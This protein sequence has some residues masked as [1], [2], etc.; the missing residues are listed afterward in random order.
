MT[1]LGQLLP[2]VVD[3]GGHAARGM[4]E[5]RA[6]HVAAYAEP[7]H[8]GCGRAPQALIPRH[9]TAVQNF[10]AGLLAR[11]ASERQVEQLTQ[12]YTR[13]L[14]FWRAN[15]I[16]RTESM[17]ATAAGRNIFWQQMSDEGV[18]TAAEWVR[19][20]VAIVPS[21]GRTCKRCQRL[22]GKRA[23]VG[24]F[25]PGGFSG[26]DAHSSCRCTERLILADTA[27]KPT[28]EIVPVEPTPSLKPDLPANLRAG[29]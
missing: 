4:I 27:D 2:L 20:W 18:I 28:A 24:G 29:G 1:L 23:Q 15:N 17:R 12:R 19:E 16:A 11:G 13:R 22:D 21:D 6:H 26:S 5:D 9:M 14:K 7:P 10:R 8:L 25:Y 3:F